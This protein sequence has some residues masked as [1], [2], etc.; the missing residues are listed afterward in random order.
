MKK[1]LFALSLLLILG[2]GSAQKCGVWRW[3]VKILTDT[4]G[5]GILNKTPI[6]TSI[7]ELA[8]QKAPQKLSTHS[9]VSGRFDGE[10]DLVR[11]DCF[12]KE[13]KR[14][15]DRDYHIV[16]ESTTGNST[17]VSEIPDPTCPDLNGYPELQKR[18]QALRDW[19]ES[20]VGNV[21]THM[22]TVDPAIPVTVIGV[23]F[24][25]APHGA[26]GATDEGREIHP[27]TDFIT[28]EGSVF[29]H[30]VPTKFVPTSE[31]ATA[32]PVQP[33]EVKTVNPGTY[34]ASD[35]LSLIAL[36][37]ILG[38]AGQVIRL[39]AGIK[40]SKDIATA[41]LSAEKQKDV[42]TATLI[43]N[44]QLVLGLLIALIVG[45]IAGVLAAFNSV[46]A[47]LDKSTMMAFLAAGYA[48]TDLIEGFVIKK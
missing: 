15:D 36:G 8:G 37:A 44:K 47:Q 39:I 7:D 14:E 6:N 10:H 23:A 11:V 27:I 26:K 34:N 48:G 33:T 17:L 19:F 28:D 3:S 46:G 22:T 1:V 35:I 42:K 30:F 43:D 5:Q 29:A 41:G 32:E 20:K 2:A 4:E 13:Y 9:N 12:I 45:G 40:K 21:S 25:D 38:M 24:W 16:L 31:T 18:Y